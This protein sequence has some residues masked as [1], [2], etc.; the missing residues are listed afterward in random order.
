MVPVFHASRMHPESAGWAEMS[1]WRSLKREGFGLVLNLD[2]ADDDI[3]IFKV[4]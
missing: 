1:G 4:Q 3:C 2:P